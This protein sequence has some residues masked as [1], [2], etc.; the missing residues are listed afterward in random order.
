MSLPH[1]SPLP[2]AATA[3]LPGAATGRRYLRAP[4]P[5]RFPVEI[6]MPETGRHLELRTTLYL[7]AKHGFA[8]TAQ[9]GCDQFV[10]WDPT[11]PAQSCAP[12]LFVRLGV[13]HAVVA[14]WKVWE[15]GAPQLAVEIIS[16]SDQGDVAWELKIGRYRRLGVNELVRFDPDDADHPVRIWDQVEGDLVERNPEDPGFAR[17]DT[18]GVF[19]FV[20]DCGGAELRLSR[21]REG[22]DLLLTPEEDERRQKIEAERRVSELEA[23]LARRSR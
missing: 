12:D 16:K 14:C 19:W 20:R 7:V 4:V 18:L 17:C 13:P 9:I 21:D 3:P 5:Q 22:T 6:E 1:Q 10:Y 11:D 2:G 8:A 15:G 23:E